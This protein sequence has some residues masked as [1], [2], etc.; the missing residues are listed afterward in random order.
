MTVTTPLTGLTGSRRPGPRAAPRPS[1]GGPPA[2][3]PAHYT[4][5]GLR[6]ASDLPLPVPPLPEAPAGPPDVE[7]RRAPAGCP[8]P[9]P[10]G[11][12][13][14]SVPCP[15]HGVDLR[16]H[17]GLDGAW[18]WVRGL[19]TCHVL[20]GARRVVVYAEPQASERALGLLLAGQV[21]VFLLHQHGCPTLHA[22]T[23]VTRHGAVAFLGAKGRG[24]S[25]I[26]A[27]FLR[28]DAV[29]LTDDILPLRPAADGIYGTPSLPLMK[30]WPPTV[31]CALGLT[32]ALPE[33]L[34][35]HGKKL[36][37]L[38]GRYPFAQ[39][40]A[41][42][43]AFYLLDRYDPA[44]RGSTETVIRHLSGHR[45]L[46]VLLSQVSHGAY[47]EPAEVARFLPLYTRAVAQAPVR[48]LSFPNGFEH[49]AAVLGRVAADLEAHR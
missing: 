1:A 34:P 3:A 17:R 5:F 36:L 29:L 7:F 44:A 19:G 48:L 49:Q 32:E 26:A 16:V 25:S 24:K 42:L 14:A 27:G 45:G 11:R 47:L 35:E 15:V 38:D 23:I 20:P 13:V 37:T 21:S 33:L 43:R 4:L 28:R 41:R 31:E 40:P 18:I 30:L 2:G 8:A 6:V 39:V 46:A 9:A 22:S 12:Q 10:A